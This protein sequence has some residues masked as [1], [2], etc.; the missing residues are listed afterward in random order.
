MVDA[1]N[2]DKQKNPLKYIKFKSVLDK[3]KKIEASINFQKIFAQKI[4]IKVDNVLKKA[5]KIIFLNHRKTENYLNYCR[6]KVKIKE[7]TIDDDDKYL[8]FEEFNEDNEN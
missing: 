2:E 3:K 8:L 5:S 7:T 1:V 4:Q 6:K